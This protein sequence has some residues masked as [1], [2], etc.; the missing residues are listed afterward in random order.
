[1]FHST[2]AGG[3][4]SQRL[5]VIVVVSLSVAQRRQPVCLLYE[6]DKN[7]IFCRLANRKRWD[8]NSVS[9][10][11]LKS[12]LSNPVF[13]FFFPS[14]QL[15]PVASD[16]QPGCFSKAT[17]AHRKLKDTKQRHKEKCKFFARKCEFFCSRSPPPVHKRRFFF[18]SFFTW[19]LQITR[20]N[21]PSK[22]KRP[23]DYDII[24]GRDL[25]TLVISP[26]SGGWFL[27]FAVLLLLLLSPNR[28]IINVF[29]I[30][31]D[32]HFKSK[33][34]FLCHCYCGIKVI[35]SLGIICFFYYFASSVMRE[36]VLF[37]IACCVIMG[38][39]EA[40]DERT[41]VGVAVSL[42]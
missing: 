3:A 15:V 24:A 31:L 19:I 12:S 10:A 28:T 38:W 11:V 27:I 34:S 30:V 33:S 40:Q 32:N 35:M 29:I 39:P 5:F 16:L 7:E 1:M 37:F 26:K 22:M 13:F 18:S 23:R 41:L 25:L 14:S 2:K 9:R 20:L 8:G 36:C 42:I 6:S 4:T 21:S 17:F